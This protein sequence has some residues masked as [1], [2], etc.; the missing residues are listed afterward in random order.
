MLRLA[1]LARDLFRCDHTASAGL[2]SGAYA[3][4]RNTCSHGRA[5]TNRFIAALM[6][7]LRPSQT[8]TIGPPNCWCAASSSPA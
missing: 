1:R 8:S 7:V 4:N 5:A 2:S 6:W 3:G